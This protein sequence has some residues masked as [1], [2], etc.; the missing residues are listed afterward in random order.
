MAVTRELICVQRESSLRFINTSHI[1]SAA[2]YK[3]WV[4]NVVKELEVWSSLRKHNNTIAIGHPKNI[5]QMYMYYS[6]L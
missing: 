1:I 2:L 4:K 5:R 6:L 3:D